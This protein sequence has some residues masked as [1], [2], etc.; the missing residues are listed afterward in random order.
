[1]MLRRVSSGNVV[2]VPLTDECVE[3]GIVA[4][5]ETGVDLAG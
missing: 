4:D 1:M 3:P 5:I 2:P